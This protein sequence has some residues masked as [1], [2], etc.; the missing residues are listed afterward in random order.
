M[1]GRGPDAPL[2]ALPDRRL[3]LAGGARWRSWTCLPEPRQHGH[4]QAGTH[5]ELGAQPGRLCQHAHLRCLEDAGQAR[6][7]ARPQSLG[8]LRGHA[9]GRAAGDGRPH[10]AHLLGRRPLHIDLAH[11]QPRR[12]F[13]P[14]GP[15]RAGQRLGRQ[16]H[17]PL[18]ARLVCLASGRAAEASGLGELGRGV[19]QRPR[20]RVERRWQRC[21]RP[22]PRGARAVRGG[23]PSLGCQW[24][25]RVSGAASRAAVSGL[26]QRGF[27]RV[28]RPPWQPARSRVPSAACGR[29]RGGWTTGAAVGVPAVATLGNR[30]SG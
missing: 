17:P 11:V 6:L 16:H 1:R 2:P 30:G 15:F 24:A 23:W 13:D 26:L 22:A 25:E 9:A 7:L 18:G 21:R 10:E 3:M 5:L 8:T 19:K 27:A 4:P 20:R 28:A 12:L 29:R 14:H